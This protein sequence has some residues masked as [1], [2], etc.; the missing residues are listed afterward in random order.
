TL[1]AQLR[2]DL[3]EQAMDLA[4]F[5]QRADHRH[6]DARLPDHARAQHRAQLHAQEIAP[7]QRDADAAPAQRGIGLRRC[8]EIRQGLVAADVEQAQRRLATLHALQ[9]PSIQAVLLFLGRKLAAL[10]IQEFGPKE[11]DAVRVRE[12]EGVQIPDALDVHL[13]LKRTAIQGRPGARRL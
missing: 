9:H 10:E 2:A 13:Y 4:Y 8:L 7:A 1:L 11:P 6:E 5:L 12:V 3:V